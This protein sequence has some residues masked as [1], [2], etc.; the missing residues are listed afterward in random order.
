VSN[1]IYMR[2]YY[3][4]EKKQNRGVL[5]IVRNKNIVECDK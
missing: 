3:N 4:E 2:Y 5:R 1:H